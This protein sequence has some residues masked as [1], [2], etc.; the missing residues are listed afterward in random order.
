MSEIGRTKILEEIEK[1]NS[2]AEQDTNNQKNLNDKT[3]NTKTGE[4]IKFVGEIKKNSQIN[5]GEIHSNKE[6][7]GNQQ[8]QNELDKE[9][10]I[11]Q[12]KGQGEEIKKDEN[13]DSLLEFSLFSGNNEKTPN[14]PK[15]E[16]NQNS[17]NNKKVL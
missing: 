7:N 14:Q 15:K 11:N 2:L 8:G 5:Q 6:E 12:N 9:K 17:D 16:N 1:K 4:S 10:N 3:N 13:S